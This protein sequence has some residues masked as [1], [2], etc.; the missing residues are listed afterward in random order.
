MR[1]HSCSLWCL[2]WSLHMRHAIL[3][4][5][6]SMALPGVR[7]L[8]NT[9]AHSQWEKYFQWEWLFNL[10]QA[11][12][13]SSP[14]H[15]LLPIS[16][17]KNDN[18]I[19]LMPSRQFLKRNEEWRESVEREGGVHL[20][21]VQTQTQKLLKCLICAESLG[22]GGGQGMMLAPSQPHTLPRLMKNLQRNDSRVIISMF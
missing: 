4:V 6:P 20:G 1:W 2:S 9:E 21:Q 14:L 12:M 10:F 3:F 19:L 17:F 7:S 18:F 5:A 8:W 11:F 15:P 16:S 22:G 13:D